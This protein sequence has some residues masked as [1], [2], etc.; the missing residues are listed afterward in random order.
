MELERVNWR[1]N[2]KVWLRVVAVLIG[3]T[4]A[5]LAQIEVAGELLVNVDAASLSAWTPNTAVSA[6]TN[7]VTLGGNFVPAVGRDVP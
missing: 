2:M 5:A 3:S 4:W 1:Q 6:W 7:A